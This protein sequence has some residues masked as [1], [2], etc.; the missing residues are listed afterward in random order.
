MVEEKNWKQILKSRSKFE[1]DA[2]HKPPNGYIVWKRE[3]WA[4]GKPLCSF[5]PSPPFLVPN[6]KRSAR[7]QEGW[8]EKEE[9]QL[10]PLFSKWTRTMWRTPIEK[11][12]VPLQTPSKSELWGLDLSQRTYCHI[13]LARLNV[14]PTL[15]YSPWFQY[16]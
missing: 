14:K 9:Q 12:R 3:K 8:G 2:H 6:C 10:K 5:P 1:T 13:I 4:N 11:T 15:K 7:F 16:S